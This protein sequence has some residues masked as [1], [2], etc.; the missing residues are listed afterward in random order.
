MIAGD[1]VG[2]IPSTSSRTLE[3]ELK[4][5]RQLGLSGAPCTAVFED[6]DNIIINQLAK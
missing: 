4:V 1:D 2:R 5:A 6:C 3:E